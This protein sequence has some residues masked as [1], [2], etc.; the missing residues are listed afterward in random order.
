M[1]VRTQSETWRACRLRGKLGRGR[2][3]RRAAGYRIEVDVRIRNIWIDGPCRADL[4]MFA[5]DI[6][7]ENVIPIILAAWASQRD[8]ARP[9]H[10]VPRGHRGRYCRR[11]ARIHGTGFRWRSCP[12]PGMAMAGMSEREEARPSSSPERRRQRAAS[13]VG[14]RPVPA[15]T[16]SRIDRRRGRPTADVVAHEPSRTMGM[17]PAI[18]Q[19]SD[20]AA[21]AGGGILQSRI[22]GAARSQRA[23]AGG[24]GC[25]LTASSG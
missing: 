14:D 10:Q 20:A 22:E 6:V 8:R 1:T 13:A 25:G 7:V 2:L 16:T 23:G 24:E 4:V 11:G 5:V 18:E 12:S 17:A 3:A 9:T 21:G 19:I 15:R